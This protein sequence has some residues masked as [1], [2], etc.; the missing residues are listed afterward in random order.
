MSCQMCHFSLSELNEDGHDYAS[1]GL[2]E[3]PEEEGSGTAPESATS[4]TA[5]DV[6]V[7]RWSSQSGQP[8]RRQSLLG[9]ILGSL[10]GED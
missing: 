3:E 1:R 7:Y 10:G 4:P 8:Q 9:E 6:P 2:R 5:S